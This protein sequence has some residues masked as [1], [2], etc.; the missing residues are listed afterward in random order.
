M[1]TNQPRYLVTIRTCS[2][3]SS[4][5]GKYRRPV[6]VR[7]VDTTSGPSDWYWHR[8]GIV[9]QWHNVDSR[10]DGPRS[11]YGQ[12]RLQAAELAAELNRSILPMPERVERQPVAA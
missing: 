8:T 2:A 11:A 3:P 5:G 9:Q 7:V 12:A 4:N 1:Q 10:Y 6:V